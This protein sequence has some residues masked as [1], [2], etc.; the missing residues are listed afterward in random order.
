MYRAAT[1]DVAQEMERNEATDKHVAMPSC[2]WLQ[3]SFFPFPVLHPMSAGCTCGDV[4]ASTTHPTFKSLKKGSEDSH[5]T[6][7]LI[8]NDGH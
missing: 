5:Q 7:V 4:G 8:N 2:A 1:L 6:I 3:L